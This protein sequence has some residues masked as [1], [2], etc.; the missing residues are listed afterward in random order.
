MPHMTQLLT[1]ED[2][3]TAIASSATATRVMME[4]MASWYA[5]AMSATDET[6]SPPAYLIR[7]GLSL[8]STVPMR[9][10]GTPWFAAIRSMAAAAPVETTTRPCASPNNN[11]REGTL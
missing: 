3:S 8:G 9:R 2:A 10:A 6:S 7:N 11:A 5:A 4:G 1:V